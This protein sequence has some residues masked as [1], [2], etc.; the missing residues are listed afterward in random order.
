VDRVI[1]GWIQKTRD[2]Y[3]I[4]MVHVDVKTGAKLGRLDREIPIAS[5]RLRV[6]VAAA[7]P[8]L[9]R[10]ED[11]STGILKVVTD[12]P[13]ADVTLDGQPAGQTPFAR[14]LKPGKHKVQVSRP[15]YQL[16]EAAWVEIPAAKEVTHKARLYPIPA[17]VQPPGTISTTV[18][19]SR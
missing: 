7:A 16:Q 2:V 13:G 9:V 3:R 1:A 19:V 14:K 4:V 17:R 15:G 8:E 5:R 11:E 18:E 6:D 12:V 10:A